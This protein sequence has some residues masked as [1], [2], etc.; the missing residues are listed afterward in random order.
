MNSQFSARALRWTRI[1]RK[2]LSVA[3]ILA[4]QSTPGSATRFDDLQPAY[5]ASFA[6]GWLG[7]GI[8]PLSIGELKLG[9][10]AQFALDPFWVPS[11]GDFAI[12]VTR[13]ANVSGAGTTSVAGIYATPVN[14]DVGSVVGLRATF[15][16]PVGPHDPTDV[17][18]I[19]VIARPGGLDPLIDAPV[20]AATLQVRGSGVRLN[21]PGAAPGTT[22]LPNVPQD[23]YDAIFD[24]TDPQPF[25]LELLI[26]RNVGHGE[27][28]L[29]VGDTVY[30]KTY[31][32]AI[33]RP[34][35]GPKIMNVGANVAI[36][37]GAGKTASVRIRDFQIYTMRSPG[38]V[39]SDPL[40]PPEFGC[41]PAPQFE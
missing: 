35:S 25:T 27:A 37:T 3:I 14:F 31:E 4:A 6:N 18:A 24:P 2:A 16:R 26:D 40:C 29:K 19:A 5:H 1:A 34:D 20:A 39:P 17:W 41:R 10:S 30:S 33:F 13:P 21:T 12:G 32:F 11:N 9:D 36:A 22:G 8:D 23:V 7:S 38:Q 15:V 28:R